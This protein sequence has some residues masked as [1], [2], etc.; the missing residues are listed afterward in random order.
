MMQSS[1]EARGWTSRTQQPITISPG[2]LHVLSHWT[3]LRAV[4]WCILYDCLHQQR[5]TG[6][7]NSWLAC[8]I[9]GCTL[10]RITQKCRLHF[11]LSSW[12]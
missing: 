5:W 9:I 6:W 1:S 2:R 4:M 7:L 8:L 3:K 10:M 11:D 12:L